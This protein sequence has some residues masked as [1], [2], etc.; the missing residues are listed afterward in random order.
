[1]TTVLSVD[2][3]AAVFVDAFADVIST[4]TGVSLDILSS[5]NDTDFYELTGVINLNSNV[6]GMLFISVSHATAQ[7]LCA[8][9]TGVTKDEVSKDDYI[10]AL[11]EIANMTAGNAK[12]RLGNSGYLFSISSPFVIEGNQKSIF[13]KKKVHVISASFDKDELSAKMKIVY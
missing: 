13:T 5:G 4:S 11:C 10:D 7:A 9:M 1:M 6:Q 3:L 12:L 8:S 2:E